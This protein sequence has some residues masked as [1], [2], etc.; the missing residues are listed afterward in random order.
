MSETDQ[1]DTTTK[2]APKTSVPPSKTH[3]IFFSKEKELYAI[4]IVVG[5]KHGETVK[6]DFTH[7]GRLRYRVPNALAERFARHAHVVSG[8]IKKA[9]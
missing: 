2:P 4:E 3:T 9:R 6:P 7:D 8:R 1:A 5:T